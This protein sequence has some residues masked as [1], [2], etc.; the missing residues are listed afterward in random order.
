MTE[1]KEYK[2]DCRVLVIVPAYNEARRIAGALADLK[3][4]APWADVLVVDDGSHDATGDIAASAGAV[5]LRLPLN[6]GVGGAMQTGYIYADRMG[7]DAAVQFDG[8][9]Q[10][11]AGVIAS[12]VRELR[13][14]GADLVVGSR[15]IGRRSYR[16]PLARYVGSRI[17]VL[18]IRILTGLRTTDPTSGFRAASRRM[19]R[20][21][22]AH[23]PQ[24]YLGD[25]A[26]ALATAAR[27]GMA[28]REVPARM[29]MTNSSSI[30]NLMGLFYMVRIAIALLIDRLERPL[31]MP[32]EPAGPA[33]AESNK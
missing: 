29:T 25:T 22:A 13:E 28:V 2:P 8:D 11:R 16:F 33:D 19:I 14:N 20:F 18:M 17:L 3:T 7:Y 4:H 32:P 5:V 31:P 27:H 24:L 30:G 12:L 1:H 9:G 26:E 15:L 6:L 10:H 23:Y 21:F